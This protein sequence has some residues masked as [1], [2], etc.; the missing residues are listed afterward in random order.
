MLLVR[1]VSE[2]THSGAGRRRVAV[3]VFDRGKMPLHDARECSGACATRVLHA[4]SG[5]SKLAPNFEGKT[6][7]A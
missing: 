7:A 2:E 1:V 5:R 3:R 6:A 4:H